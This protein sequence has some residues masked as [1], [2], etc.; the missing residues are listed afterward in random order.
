MKFTVKTVAA[1]G[2]LTAATFALT[3]LHA[4]GMDR[5]QTPIDLIFQKGNY[6]ELSFGMATAELSGR[7][8][9]G[10]A[11]SDIA[12]DF[13]IIGAGLKMQFSEKFSFSLIFDQPYWAD[14]QYG[15][16][17][18]TTMLGGSMAKADSSALTAI[19]KYNFNDRYSVYGGP[20]L[21]QADGEIT[22]S[23]NAY[24]PLNG[25]NVKFG[26]DQALGYVVG[27]AYEIPKIAFRASLTYHSRI[28]LD[29]PT[30]Q[31]APGGVPTTTPSTSSDLPQSIKLAVQSG[32]A[33]D[34]VVFG[35]VRWS[36]WSKF[37]LDPVGLTPNLASLEDSMTYE[38]GV[39]RRFTDKI[40]ARV[41]YIYESGGSDDL[42]SPL[43]PVNGEQAVTLGGTYQI[44]ETVSLS[45]GLRYTWLGDGNP[46]TGNTSR[47]SF[48]NNSA[49][50]GGMKIGISF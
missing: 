43:S 5:T 7:D 36:E 50:S 35:S 19:F 2:T 16:N 22:L 23:G 37:E 9:L 4:G 38:I 18:A 29:L 21:V 14:V 41:S 33:A 47:G 25:Y 32:V 34:T 48:T 30:I 44:N 1:A 40:S 31:T 49:I 8:V 24:G 27:A 11:I 10:N 26:K 15:G 28:A 6:G 13:S 17:P 42:V 46:E 12:G 20:R 39:G 3:P 45:A